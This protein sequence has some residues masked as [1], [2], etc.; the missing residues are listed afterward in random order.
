MTRHFWWSLFLNHKHSVSFLYLALLNSPQQC[1]WFQFKHL[2]Y[3]LQVNPCMYFILYIVSTVVNSV[4][5]V[6]RIHL[7]GFPFLEITLSNCLMTA[8]LKTMV[9]YIF[10]YFT[11]DRG[12]NVI[13]FFWFVDWKLD[14]L[15]NIRLWIFSRL[16]GAAENR[17]VPSHFSFV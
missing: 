14:H 3:I 8:V 12:P 5:A 1:L 13:D 10:F 15:S 2:A 9:S 4:E 7:I 6:F 11:S 16:F 17:F